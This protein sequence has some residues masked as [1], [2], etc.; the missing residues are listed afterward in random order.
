MN[1][2]AYVHSAPVTYVDLDGAQASRP[3]SRPTTAPTT[4]PTSR[5]AQ[6]TYVE[7]SFLHSE[8]TYFKFGIFVGH[9]AIG[10]K[11]RTGGIKVFD[12]VGGRQYQEASLQQWKESQAEACPRPC[13]WTFEML[14]LKLSRAAANALCLRL[15]GRNDLD[16]DW[17]G[18][19]GPSTDPLRPGCFEH[20]CNSSVTGDMRAVGINVPATPDSGVDWRITA[21]QAGE[22]IG[23]V[24]SRNAADSVAR[25]RR[26]GHTNRWGVL[27]V[28]WLEA[29]GWVK[30][31]K[32]E[33]LPCKG[34]GRP[35]G[36]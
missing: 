28:P 14:P 18:E 3:T 15:K 35:P 19:G 31:K 17:F 4:G 29:N 22:A 34:G 32:T 2:Y 6:L 26:I 30:G 21:A 33:R 12:H 16:W 9:S 13:K 25:L 8:D 23:L 24:S 5:P 20:N 7:A 36:P 27:T 1:L 10:C 11:R